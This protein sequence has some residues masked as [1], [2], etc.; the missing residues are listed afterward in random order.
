MPRDVALIANDAVFR[1][2][3]DRFKLLRRVHWFSVV[4]FSVTNWELA[5]W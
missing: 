4:R 3:G 1:H 2:G 5:K